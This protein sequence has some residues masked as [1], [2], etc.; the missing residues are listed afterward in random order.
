[1][2][3][4]KPS[5]LAKWLKRAVFIAVALVTLLALAY[6]IESYRA[7]RLWQGYRAELEAQGETLD[8]RRL[9]P[10]PV[11]DDNNFFMTPLLRPLSDYVVDGASGAVGR[12]DSKACDRV[13]EMFAWTSRLRD[14][15]PG[16]Q[17]G[18]FRDLAVWQ[19]QLRGLND[20]AADTAAGAPADAPP[21]VVA[22]SDGTQQP[23]SKAAHP[24]LEALAARPMGKPAE[25]LL[26][27]LAQNQAALDEIRDA[28]Q[29][30]AAN[31]KARYGE[32]MELLLQQLASLKAMSR[33]LVCSAL[34]HLAADDPASAA[35][36]VR[37]ALRLADALSE[38]PLLVA[39]L[40]RIALTDSAM[41]GLW[42]GLARHEWSEPQLVEFEGA[43]RCANFVKEMAHC[44]RGERAF[45]IGMIG[46]AAEVHEAGSRGIDASATR[47]YDSLP[48]P[49]KYQN[50]YHIAR[51]YQ[52]HLLPAF[53][54]V[55]G[56]IDVARL[57]KQSIEARL[58]SRTPYNLFA[59]MMGPPVSAAARNAAKAQATV[60]LARVAVAIERHRLDR[61]ALP[62]SLEAL[63]PRYLNPVPPDP[64]NGQ[65][66]R[67]RRGEG[68]R[69]TLYSLGMN[70]Q[71]DQAAVAV[72]RHHGVAGRA[73]VGDWVWQNHPVTNTV[74]VSS[75]SEAE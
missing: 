40:V 26:F 16:W 34:A 33:P 69:F 27:A 7:R 59:S 10:E 39:A 24:V 23:V 28:A 50:Q 72:T 30:P 61:G 46:G 65:P 56:T 55:A 70:G 58:G 60:N 64:V 67:Y 52:E 11:P 44:L 47:P 49:M 71:D 48:G 36:D 62:D 3:A 9:L 22:D 35:R 4:W 63:A 42:E 6:A 43:L 25:D 29:R 45:A 5:R 37:A 75:G 8:F 66:L 12:R 74:V 14:T 53:D 32:D 31:L 73:K 38:E 21:D 54:P 20:G 19:R 18:Q 41:Q 2:N 13:T 1:M 57:D 68:D 17:M 51:L 15:N